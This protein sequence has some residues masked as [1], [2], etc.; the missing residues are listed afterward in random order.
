MKLIKVLLDNN[1]VYVNRLKKELSQIWFMGVTDYFLIHNEIIDFMKKSDILY[2]IRGSGVAS[3]VNYCLEIS[4]VDP[5]KWKLLFE[6]FLNP[7]R[8]TQYDL[9]FKNIQ[10]I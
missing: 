8:G 7:G 10:K 5:V 4:N 2:G 3:L 1:K 9:Q 6:R